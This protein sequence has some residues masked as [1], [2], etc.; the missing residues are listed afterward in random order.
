MSKPACSE[1]EFIKLFEE[2]G[3]EQTARLLGVAPRNVHKRRRTIEKNKGLTLTGPNPSG[4]VPTGSQYDRKREL[5]ITDGKILI[6]SDVHVWPHRETTAMRGF[7]SFAKK[8]KPDLVIINGDLFDGAST[9]RHA[10]IGWEWRPTAAQEIEA[11]NE[12]TSKIEKASPNSKR[13]LTIGN[14][15]IRIETMLSN[16]VPEVEGLFGTTIK[17]H[18]PYWDIV[19]SIQVNDNITIKHRYRSGIH[20]AWNNQLYSGHTLVTGDTHRLLV[21]PFSDYNGVRYGIETGTMAEPYGDQFHYAEDNPRDWRSGFVLLTIHDGELLT[22]EIVRV[23]N[24]EIGR[25]EFRGGTI[26]V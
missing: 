1:E 23:M 24:E 20:A 3:P 16:R 5:Q 15:D 8:F 6:G 14:H 26:D 17:D 10:R 9:S 7:V 21:R 2:F 25:L 13:F 11:V 19:W 18:L 4:Q 12:F 22:P